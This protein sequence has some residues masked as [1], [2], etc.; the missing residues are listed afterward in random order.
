M[1]AALAASEAGVE[2]LV[3]E[4]ESICAGSTA[5][6]SGMI[7]AC[8]TRQQ[9]IHEID[10]SV[11]IMASDIQ[12]KA[13]QMADTAL[14]RAVC[15]ASGPLVDWLSQ[16][17]DIEL[18]LVE[19]F[20][21]PGHSRLRMHAPPSRS[22]ADLINGLRRAA[23]DAGVTIMTNCRVDQLFVNQPSVNQLSVNQQGMVTGLRLQRPDG[24]IERI[25]CGS[26]VLACNGFGGN[27]D[28][29]KQYI[30]E[31]SEA[32]YFGHPGN[33]GDAISW[34][35]E[36]GAMTSD[37]GS[38]QGHGSVA[39]PHGILISWALMMEGGIQ[40]NALGE[41]FSN[42]HGG[43]S[44][45]ARHVIDQPQGIAWNIYDNRLHEMAKGF[46]DYRQ[47]IKAD[48]VK[49][50]E[51]VEQLAQITNTPLPRLQKT[52]QQVTDMT[53][54]LV[55]DSHGRDFTNKPVLAP[56]FYVTRVTGAL[57]HTQGGLVV[58]EKARVLRQSGGG[59][60]NLFAGGGAAGGV[61]GPEDWGYLSGNGLLT[62]L[63]LGRIAGTSAVN[64]LQS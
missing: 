58:D 8:G 62:A 45:Q 25:A 60:P 5:L 34:G 54:G 16:T 6:S 14:V 42:E 38:Y 9:L 35:L 53:E 56:P 28:M 3:L 11:S 1:A 59:F 46:E 24:S 18:T 27:P 64:T 19:G 49:I 55:D 29:V 23:E 31:M 30:P 15:E 10:D 32:M 4:R 48:A 2:T 40:I 43:Y 39:H 51:D 13:R 26:I 47:A 63:T 7:P 41:R 50:A 12:K 21:Y 17:Y 61:S 57:F 52:L 44:E 36:L 37:L 33:Q 20:L 22:G